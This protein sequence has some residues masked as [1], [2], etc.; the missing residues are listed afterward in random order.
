[1]TGRPAGGDQE[2]RSWTRRH[3]SRRC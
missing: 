1:V 2:A 3:G